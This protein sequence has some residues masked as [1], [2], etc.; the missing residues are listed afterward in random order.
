MY[1]KGILLDCMYTLVWAT[2]EAAKKV[3]IRGHL[4]SLHLRFSL[5]SPRQAL[6]PF[7][8]SNKIVLSRVWNPPSQLSE[9]SL[10]SEKSDHWQSIGPSK[11]NHFVFKKEK[12]C[13]NKAYRNQRETF[14]NLQI[15]RWLFYYCLLW[16][17]IAKESVSWI[18]MESSFCHYW[19]MKKGWSR[20]ASYQR[21]WKKEASSWICLLLLC[22]K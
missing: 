15:R 8:G 5:E 17:W 6:P 13:I 4:N 14:V 1:T 16:N 20:V 22:L 11:T 21:H 2:F 18:V 10:H 12:K 7:L 19:E 3:D 9:H